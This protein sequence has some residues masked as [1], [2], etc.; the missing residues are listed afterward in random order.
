METR[1][2]QNRI[3]EIF[4]EVVSI[5]RYLHMHP[6][7]SN[8]EEETMKYVSEC[9]TKLG[10]PNQ[11]NVGG[12]GV[13]GLIGDPKADFSI[14][15]RADMD[16]LPIQEMNEIPYASKVPGVMHACGHDIHTATLL[17]TAKLLKEMEGELPGA[18]KLFFQPAEEKG[19][20]ARQMIADGCMNNPPVRRVLGFHVDVGKPAGHVILF[21]EQVSACSTGLSITVDGKACHGSRPDTGVD[22]IVASAHVLIALQNVASRFISPLRPVVVS[23][24]MIQGGTRSN[25][26]A[27]QVEMK[28]TIRTLDIKTRD[29]VKEKVQIAAEGAAAS[30]GATVTLAMRDGYPA[31]VNDRAT[32]ALLEDIAKEVLGPDGYTIRT[33]PGMGGEDF[34]YFASEVPSSFFRLGVL[35]EN[36]GHKQNL[37]NEWFCPDES[38]M[39]NGMLMEVLGVLA[40]QEEERARIAVSNP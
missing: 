36:G 39:K 20:G 12:H 9:L 16:A 35:G 38:C 19:G 27:G 34:S 11:T 6:E 8:Q 32:T 28:G 29:L 13:V 17:G 4:D 26:L 21:P 1:Q 10:I 40:L 15:L 14:G 31:V 24:G 37:H 5:R 18:V 23:V 3:E 22:A 25:I 7:L 2:I 33:E 30:C